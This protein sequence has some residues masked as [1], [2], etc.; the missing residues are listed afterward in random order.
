MT[1][2]GVHV[3]KSKRFSLC[4][5]LFC[6]HC[7]VAS[8]GNGQKPSASAFR[9]VTETERASVLQNDSHAAVGRRNSAD[10]DG[11]SYEFANHTLCSKK[12]AVKR[13]VPWKA[14]GDLRA[15]KQLCT[16]EP[17]C[18][19]VVDWA[20]DGRGFALCLPMIQPWGKGV[21]FGDGFRG[22]AY[23]KI[24][25][26][27]IENQLERQTPIMEQAQLPGTDKVVEVSASSPA[28]KRGLLVCC[29]GPVMFVARFV[30]C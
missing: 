21:V 14:R 19:A 20:C 17:G 16:E 29:L 3:V 8:M 4:A 23:K 30:C 26:F 6:M 10:G 22:C 7:S 9:P 27:E 12:N 28:S 25:V 2:H 24:M 1:N 15:A 18:A 11:D 13:D 5:V